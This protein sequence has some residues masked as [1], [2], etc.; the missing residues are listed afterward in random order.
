MKATTSVCVI[1]AVDS[2]TE[3]ICMCVFSQKLQMH[4]PSQMYPCCF[5]MAAYPKKKKLQLNII[6][7][8]TPVLSLIDLYP[9][10]KHMEVLKMLGSECKSP[11][12]VPASFIFLVLPVQL[13][14]VLCAQALGIVLGR[15]ALHPK[16]PSPTLSFFLDF[17]AV[18]LTSLT[19]CPLGASTNTDTKQERSLPQSDFTLAVGKAMG[20][21]TTAKKSI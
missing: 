5:K 21:M 4:I 2:E 11:T 13:G 16:L 10:Y 20:Q 15:R 8:Y 19:T 1:C 3:C 12:V 14:H 18:F 7:W 17:T 9:Q 6:A